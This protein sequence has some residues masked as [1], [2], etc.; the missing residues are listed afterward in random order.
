[1]LTL[2]LTHCAISD[3][4]VSQMGHDI[5][6]LQ[7]DMDEL[8]HQFKDGMAKMLAAIEGRRPLSRPSTPH[9]VSARLQA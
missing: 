9:L 3:W 4:R 2:A 5:S 8:K 7:N 6:R 1:M